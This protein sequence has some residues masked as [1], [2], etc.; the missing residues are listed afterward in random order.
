MEGYT[1]ENKEMVLQ[2]TI[3]FIQYLKMIKATLINAVV[4]WISHLLI[5][6]KKIQLLRLG[7]WLMTPIPVKSKGQTREALGW[8]LD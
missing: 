8:N 1:A 7:T 5:V 2:R 6:C 4:K 3:Q